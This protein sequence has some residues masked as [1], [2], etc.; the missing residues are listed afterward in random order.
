MIKRLGLFFLINMAVMVTLNLVVWVVM[1]LYGKTGL[2]MGSYGS[3]AVFCLVWG[4]GG[5][6]ISLLI[7]KR[8]AIWTMGLEVI[9][10]DTMNPEKRRLVQTVHR[11]AQSAHLPKMPD[12][13]IYESPDVNAFATGPS[14]SNSLV[15]VSTGLLHSMSTQEVDG[16]LGHEVS[17]IANGD[18][19]TMTLLQGVL[20]AFVL[21]FS[22]IL[23]FAISSALAKGEN[24]RDQSPSRMVTFLVEMVLQVVF[25]I[26]AHMILAWF[27]RYREYRADRG[28]A[29]LAGKMSMIRALERLKAV[30][31]R[32]PI[33]AQADDHLQNFKISGSSSGFLAL[34]STHPPLE[35]RIKALQDL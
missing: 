18:M 14:R 3:L 16:V 11:L 19:V 23:A 28:G 27:S 26:A 8:M 21:F 5:S 4:M 15:A 35:E 7:S 1:G 25:G 12:V 9:D 33:L 6:L 29:D 10:P 32:E 24:D 20:N 34:F 17:H 2:P 31:S 13:A 22:K 30:T